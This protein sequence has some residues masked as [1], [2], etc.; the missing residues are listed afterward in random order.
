M[1][2]HQ[3]DIVWVRFPYSD[4]SEGKFR[5]ALVVS[6]DQYNKKGS[7]VVACAVTSKL[8]EKE[9]SILIDESDIANGKLPMK[10]RIRSD[11]IMQIEQSLIAGAFARLDD[12][13]FDR[14]TGEIMK[15]V[16]RGKE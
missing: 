11:K 16:K 9:Y 15:L 3:Q 14:I 10:S 2:A 8:D 1:K 13:A 4:L 6:N 5:P 12:A 7:D